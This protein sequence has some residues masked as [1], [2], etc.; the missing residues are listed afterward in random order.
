ML[1]ARNS[2]VVK[3]YAKINVSLRVL[4][5]RP[6]EYHELEMVNLPLELHD[7]IE[8]E[9]ASMVPDTFITCD[10][11]GLANAR[12]NL[13]KKAVDAMRNE[14]H[15][16]D[17][18]NIHIHKEIPFAAGLGGGSSNAA[19]VILAI[20]DLL[21][22]KADPVILSQVGKSIGADV[23]FFLLNKPA[24]VTG[25]GEKIQI[26]RVLNSYYCLIVKPVQGLSTTSVF[27]VADN[28][29]RTPIDTQNVIK[30]LGT[31][32]D[33]LLANSIGND[34]YA[35]AKSLLPEIE[36]IVHSLQENGFSIVS[37]SGSG[38]AVFALSLDQKKIKEAAKKYE[39][40]GYVVRLTKTS[41]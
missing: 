35:P 39:K 34:L 6:D 15:F 10:D 23:P 19:A 8:I 1:F 38:S 17:N 12:H 25:I 37:M 18:F 20:V 5:K 30:A 9:K 11:I 41:I 14:Y 4:S 40:L 26:I 21:H 13:C 2:L 33:D 31:G 29:V 32:N 24:L 36:T 22:I 16:S 27:A 7:V 3:S 28:F